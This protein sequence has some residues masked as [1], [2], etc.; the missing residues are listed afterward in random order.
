MIN[1]TQILEHVRTRA[2]RYSGGYT[3][4]DS[5]QTTSQNSPAQTE[6]RLQYVMLLQDIKS[7]LQTISQKELVVDSRKVRDG[8]KRVEQ[9][10][11]NVSR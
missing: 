8:I 3:A 4:E 7:L 1:T 6:G 9:L 2:G 11:R 5:V 10:E